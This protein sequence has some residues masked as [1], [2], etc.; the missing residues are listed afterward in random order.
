MP[1]PYDPNSYDHNARGFINEPGRYKFRVERA[2]ETRSKNGDPMLKLTLSVDAG[3]S[4][5]SKCFENIVLTG[6]ALRRLHDFLEA[7]GVPFAPPPETRDIEGKA[8]EA[9]FGVEEYNGYV[10]LKVRLYCFPE[11]VRPTVQPM[12]G[13]DVPF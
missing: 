12:D 6:A 2:E 10:N 3:G 8:G 9:D 4:R 1:L 5:A 13:G 11:S 7:I